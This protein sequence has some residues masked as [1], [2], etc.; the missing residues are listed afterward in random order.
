MV[1]RRV[2][3]SLTRYL[4]KTPEQKRLESLYARRAALDLVIQ[5]LEDYW[6]TR[7][8]RLASTLLKIA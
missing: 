4:Q 7:A 6:R 1:S 2:N 8:K 5:R 3:A